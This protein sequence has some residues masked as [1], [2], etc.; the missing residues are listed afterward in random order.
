MFL[1]IL[2][3][4]LIVTVSVVHADEDSIRI[5]AVKAFDEFCERLTDIRKD[6]VSQFE[7]REQ[8]A[9]NKGDRKEIDAL[10]TQRLRFDTKHVIPSDF[11]DAF[12]K[13]HEASILRLRKSYE[14][15]EKAATKDKLDSLATRLAEELATIDE[16]LHPTLLLTGIEPTK[17]KVYSN[18]FSRDGRG[19]IGQQLG[20]KI[21]FGGQEYA[22]AILAH[23]QPK[24]YS[25]ALYDLGEEGWETFTARVGVPRDPNEMKTQK[26]KSDLTFE[27]M[28]DEES[29]WRS[30]PTR[31]MDKL[32]DCRVSLPA[33][34]SLSLRAH[35]T[36]E[37][38][39]ARA[40]WLEPRLSSL[41]F[42]VPDKTVKPHSK[43]Q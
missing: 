22:E 11:P 14:T 16:Q 25:E 9:R 26:L 7:Q 40:V 1:R 10:S 20:G 5:D 8:K 24:D 17:V 18:W 19:M 38:H 2:I 3:C 27:V 28:A 36:L 41:S 30:K 13:R 32:Q 43:R 23:P 35:S 31:D 6:I 39:Y 12:R 34:K 21:L 37:N 4:W 33:A 15:A 29:L 42:R